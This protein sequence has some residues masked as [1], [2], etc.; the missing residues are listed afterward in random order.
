MT[1]PNCGDNSCRYAKKIT[2]MRTNGGCKCDECPKCGRHVRPGSP[3][4][5][6]T[7]CPQQEWLPPHH[8]KET[9]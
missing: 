6:T 4:K 7:W 5:H 3:M 2:G 8:R 1:P 9:A